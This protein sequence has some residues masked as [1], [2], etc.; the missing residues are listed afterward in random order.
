MLKKLLGLDS[1]QEVDNIELAFRGGW[2]LALLLIVAAIALAIFLYR[3]ETSISRNRRFLMMFCKVGALLTLIVLVMKP[4]ALI[5]ETKESLPTMLVL[6]DTSKS[7]A[8]D[9]PRKSRE[10]VEE[11][12]KALNKLPLEE[13][14]KSEDTATLG[15]S[16]GSTRRIDL[17]RGALTHPGINVLEKLEEKYDVRLFTFDSSI[18]SQS[19]GDDSDGLG[20]LPILNTPDG[21]SSQVGTAL[22]EAVGRFAGQSLAGAMVISD[23]SWVE[24]T[25]PVRVA[26]QLKDRVPLYSVAVGLPSPPDIRLLSVVGPEV[27][28]KGDRVPLRVKFESRGYNGLKVNLEMKIDGE[29]ADPKEVEL[30][31]GVQFAEMMFVP[32]QD[33][34]T[35]NLEFTIAPRD[36]ETSDANNVAT[37]KV[38]ILDEKI[39][40]LYIEGMPR[41]EFRYLRW[42]LLRDRRL[43]VRFLMTQGDSALAGSSPHHIGRF[44]EDPKEALKYD[45]IIL[46]DVPASYFN[47][48]QTKLIEQLVRERGGSLLMLAGPVAAPSTYRDTPLG[49]LLPVNLGTGGTGPTANSVPEVTAAGQ[50]SLITS[51]SLSPET[52]AAVW[53][54]VSPMWGLPNLDGPKPGATVLLTLRGQNDPNKPPY[55]LVAWQRVGTGKSLFVGT[56]D[57]WRMRQEVGDRFHSR[58]WGQTIQFLTLSRLLGENKQITIETDRSTY[59]TGDQI[60]IFANVLTE[61]FD[62]VD[63]PTYEV[64]LEPEGKP[65]AGASI[66]LTPVEGT[67]GL[68]TG[69]YT[70]GKDGGYVLKTQPQDAEVS[71]EATFAIETVDI[72]D[73][74]TAMQPDVAK[75]IA[76][77]SGG[78]Q[79]TLT[80]L[81]RFAESLEPAEKIST[82]VKSERDLWDSP[83]WFLLVIAFAGAEWYLRRK[84]NLV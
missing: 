84:E 7:M 24:G 11:A 30:K 57:L 81:G 15:Q 55:P 59:S 33:T 50:E 73:R 60:R 62:P 20:T 29:S 75:Q 58:F 16:L 64:V 23:F 31:E 43:Q 83:L 38:R 65:D 34:G 66:E 27:V 72:E 17:A 63:A 70:A 51:L 78:Q 40:V 8:L 71:N 69:S 13:S 76:E 45:L 49:S 41:W 6:L 47:A 42:V 56:E 39:K 79:L 26:H 46:G 74:E 28:F 4:F 21:A 48:A 19:L 25:D 35:I 36:D 3:R 44:P 12:A 67:P 82:V 77:I 18:Q 80:G 54:K 10:D 1:S 52:S 32:Q 22:S 37:H 61:S 9:D 5:R 2:F 14:L 68:F 53:G